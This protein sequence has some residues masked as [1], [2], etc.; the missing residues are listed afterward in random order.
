MK[1]TAEAILAHYS[2]TRGV[3]HSYI[4]RSDTPHIRMVMVR[5]G[6]NEV[7]PASLKRLRGRVQPLVVDHTVLEAI[8]RSYLQAEAEK[9][10]VEQQL[11]QRSTEL[12]SVRQQLFDALGELR[13]L[14]NL[15]RILGLPEK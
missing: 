9:T 10:E 4:T 12:E 15:V 6:K 5:P 13:Y 14:R 11:S 1:K 7:S 3:G 2:A 8:C